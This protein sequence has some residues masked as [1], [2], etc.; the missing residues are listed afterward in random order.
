MSTHAVVGVMHGDVCKS[1]YVHSDGYPEYLGQ[2]LNKYYDSTKANFL[3]A[4]GDCSM[5]GMEIG[6]K[7]DFNDRMTYV[8]DQEIG[9][10]IATQCRFYKRDRDED[11]SWSVTH[12]F[13]ELTDHYGSE[14]YYIMQ[15]GVWYVSIG[16]R[17]LQVLSGLINV[18]VEA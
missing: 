12:S 17:S 14:F 18:A 15:D 6:E 11:T 2:V 5:V 4:Q 13:N 3:V 7:I 8:E 9:M 1:I 10:H 16:G